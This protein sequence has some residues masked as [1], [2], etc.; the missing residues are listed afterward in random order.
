MSN[1]VCSRYVFAYPVSNPTAVHTAKVIKDMKTKHA[2]FPTLNILDKKSVFVSH[3][4]LED[5]ELLG[6]TLKH[7]VTKHA[8]VIGVPER[9]HAT[10]KT[11]LKMTAGE[12]RK[13][14]HKYLPIAIVNDNTTYHSSI[15]YEPNRVFHG[16]VPHNILDHKRGLQFNPNIAPTTDFAEELLRRTRI[17]YD[18][19]NQ[20][21]VQSYIKYKRY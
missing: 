18:T 14:W 21:V 19:T 12:Y 13:Q 10:I 2:Y 6:I 8:Q 5:A 16:I 1:D 3:G 20:Y 17:L 15:D 7:A 4:I 9:A 11:S